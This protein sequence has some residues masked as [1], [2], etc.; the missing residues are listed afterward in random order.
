MKRIIATTLLSLLTFA[1]TVQAH[2]PWI[3][4][5][6]SGNAQIFFGETPADRTYKVPAAMKNVEVMGMDAEGQAKPI[7]VKEVNSD[8]F[9][10]FT[11][12]ASVKEFKTLES[13]VS[14]GAY[15]GTK[16]DYTMQHS[17][18]A[19]KEA[20]AETKAAPKL[21]AHV[22]QVDNGYEAKIVFDGQ[23]VASASVQLFTEDGTMRSQGTTDNSGKMLF[24]AEEVKSGQ[25]W[26]LVGHKV[27]G[28]S[29][30]INGKKYESES[31]Y[32]TACFVVE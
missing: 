10:G 24:S 20:A 7:A 26:L 32:L 12:D 8:S 13:A 6:S 11:S 21:T 27:E 17:G 29:G 23:P 30:E 15:H 1:S 2:Y 18:K 3:A 4:I 14:Y 28:V 25:N 16:L 22:Q 5:D 9:V 19:T 31:H